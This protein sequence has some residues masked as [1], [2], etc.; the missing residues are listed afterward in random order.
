MKTLIGKSIG[1]IDIVVYENDD[2]EKF[3]E[4]HA[5]NDDILPIMDII[6]DYL[7]LY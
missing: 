5:D 2:G 6:E 3:L 1:N 4:I 7:K